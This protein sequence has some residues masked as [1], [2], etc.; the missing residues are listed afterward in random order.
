MNGRIV[1]YVPKNVEA[2]YALVV[3]NVE[4]GMVG[5]F[6]FMIIWLD[7]PAIYD[8]LRLVCYNIRRLI[9]I[10]RLKWRRRL[11]HN[12][13][14]I[15]NA[16][17]ALPKFRIS[18]YQKY[19]NLKKRQEETKEWL[20]GWKNKKRLIKLERAWKLK[21]KPKAKTVSEETQTNE[22]R[23]IGTVKSLRSKIDFEFADRLRERLKE[24]RRPRKPN[25]KDKAVMAI[26]ET[27]DLSDAEKK[28]KSRDY[29]SC[30]DRAND[31][32][33]W[34]NDPN[35]LYWATTDSLA[36]PSTVYTGSRDNA[37]TIA[38]DLIFST[39]DTI[40]KRRKLMA[41]K[42]PL[43]TTLAPKNCEKSRLCFRKSNISHQAN[44]PIQDWS[45]V[46]FKERRAFA[47]KRES[48]TLN[49]EESNKEK[50]E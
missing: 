23:D 45:G 10:I 37:P 39:R 21:G 2:E 44:N 49:I 33:N 18:D 43:N 40:A 50:D 17:L 46:K 25:H 41:P 42:D 3:G 6:V 8:A 11:H 47:E 28:R 22:Y 1:K 9:L 20:E 16:L 7:W 34:L 4:L 24:M 13:I 38:C 26:L 27:Y 30:R 29:V 32:A 48:I 31:R 14:P 5:F 19:V 36:A 12:V 35:I 15:L